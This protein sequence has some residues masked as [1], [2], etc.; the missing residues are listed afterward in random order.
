MAGMAL[1]QTTA[2][3]QTPESAGQPAAS[4][5]DCSIYPLRPP[6]CAKQCG[7]QDKIQKAIQQDSSLSGGNIN[8]NV[9]GDEVEL[10]GAVNSKDQKKTA[11]QIAESNAGGMK[12]VDH[13][14]VSGGENPTS[15]STPPKN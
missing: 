13:L 6:S 14:K 1:P 5:C 3:T 8:V 11:K 4:E 7:I 10:S 2:T 9:S 12:V 15:P